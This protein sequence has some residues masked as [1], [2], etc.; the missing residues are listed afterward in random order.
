MAQTVLV[1]LTVAGADTGPFNIYTD[2]DGYTVPVATNVPKASLLA[3]Y[4]VTVPD[5]ATIIQVKSTGVC[6]NSYFMPV[7]TTTTTST[8]T[9]STSTTT[10]T[11]TTLTPISLFYSSISV[12]DVCTTTNTVTVYTNCD[13]IVANCLFWYDAAGTIIA[14]EYFYSNHTT[15]AVY[16]MYVTHF[17][18][19]GEVA[20]VSSC[21]TSCTDCYRWQWVIES[22]PTNDVIHYYS[23]SDGSEQIKVITNGDVPGPDDPFGILSICNCNDL[24]NP[25]TDN[26]TVLTQT[27][28]CTEAGEWYQIEDCFQP[29]LYLYS[30]QYPANSF[31]VGD[32]VL[33][34]L[35]VFTVVN[36]I[37]TPPPS[38]NDIELTAAINPVTYAQLTGCPD[39]VRIELFPYYD[40]FT[41][42]DKVRGVWASPAVSGPELGFSGTVK[43]YLNTG[44]NNYYNTTYFAPGGLNAIAIDNGTYQDQTSCQNL[45]GASSPLPSLSK[46]KITNLTIYTQATPF[47]RDVN[48]C[49][50]DFSAATVVATPSANNY[51]GTY[52][53]NL[54]DS[55]AGD[56]IY[57]EILGCFSCP[58]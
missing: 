40:D 12:E 27:A 1:T 29:G 15:G 5:L 17:F 10:T 46:L 53:F 26:G 56:Y 18:G 43:R 4:S 48:G 30:I 9:S 25:T 38:P 58:L 32:R 3:G 54:Y 57:F 24:G 11:T 21:T 20:V 39:I 35:D 47:A 37:T 55:I 22:V 36:I 45:A 50:T 44:C 8:S 7:V 28:R 33:N 19:T 16:E 52:R 23:C 51:S 13:P 41:D 14:D 6:T 2:A 34:G 42:G 31:E 49:P